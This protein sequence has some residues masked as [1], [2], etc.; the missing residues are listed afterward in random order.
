[1]LLN[2]RSIVNKVHELQ[3]L[4]DALGP[5]FM[6]ITETWLRMSI[7]NSF[8]V[9]TNRY[10]VI[11]RDR[12]D[13]VGGG[14][15]ALVDKQYTVLQVDIVE[16]VEVV[17]FDVIFT[18]CHKYRFILC[19]R[20]PEYGAAACLY[21]TDL[22]K[23]LT[24]LCSV[25]HTVLI[26]GD[27]NLPHVDWDSMNTDGLH[28]DTHRMFV[29]FVRKSGFVQFVSEPTRNNSI[30]DILLANDPQ[31]IADYKLSAPL[32]NSDH[33]SVLFNLV[34]PGVN[35]CVSPESY[36]SEANDLEYKYDFTCTD[37]LGFSA[38]LNSIH[39]E[40]LYNSCADV[41]ECWNC[42]LDVMNDGIHLF[43]PL[44]LVRISNKNAKSYPLHIRKLIRKKCAAWRLYKR[45][46]SVS[47]KQK[48][49]SIRKQ[50]SISIA[51]FVKQ[52]EDSIIRKGNL[53]LFYKYVNNKLSCK[54]GVG[55][56]RDTDGSVI[57]D[58]LSKANVLNDHFSSVFTVDNG[59]CTDFASRTA[60]TLT[61]IT[62][63]AEL[64][65]KRLCKLKVSSSPGPD[66]LHACLLKNLAL[67]LAM[68][69][70][71]LFS[72]SF[73]TSS[74]PDIWKFAV[75]CPVFKKGMSSNVS[76]YRPISLT[77][78][79][80]KIM[81]AIVKDQVISYMLANDLIT[82]QQH[83][84]LSRHSTCS[85]LIESV[86][87]WTL[88]LNAR[89]CVDV[90]YVDFSKAFDCVVHSKLIYKLQS[91]G[92]GGPLLAWIS[93]FLSNRTQAVRVGRDLSSCRQV[94]SGVPQGSVLG[95]LL[96]LLYINDIVDIFGSK[97]GVKL[98]A[99]D[100]KIY[101]VM[102]DVCSKEVLQIGLDNLSVWC[103]NWQMS[104]SVKKCFV[105]QLGHQP[106]NCSYSVENYV[107]PVS[108]VANDL[109]VLI[110]SKLRFSHQYSKITT[111][112]HQRASLI[113]RCFECRDPKLLFRAFTVYVRPILEYCSPVWSPVYKTDVKLLESVQKRFTKKLSGLK[114]MP[115]K[116]RLLFLNTDSL[117][118]RRLRSDLATMYKIVHGFDDT[119]GIFEFRVNSCTRGGEL[120]ILKPH[121]NN[122]VRA[123]SFACRHVD[124]WNELP[125][126][127]RNAKSLC[128]FKRLVAKFDFSNFLVNF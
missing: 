55:V 40:E 6:L 28:D 35:S 73:D 119:T 93:D 17:A 92:I 89:H 30:L 45:Y 51:A 47:L 99:D 3:A 19:Y 76:N 42:F 90:V 122:N 66:G 62:F 4:L 41:N 112:A 81:E 1:V 39:W 75:V 104:L 69:L 48:Y 124:C 15:C 32:A 24:K 37:Y 54:S 27:F 125:E 7:P 83:G 34:L 105:L 11:R 23:C 77:S 84:F 70:S 33:E 100:V 123:H 31:V 43:T 80:C 36:V 88:A 114:H 20:K 67:P 9:D 118:L 109:G 108:E 120:K 116:D 79:V 127:T 101:L 53:G 26:A 110:D 57:S 126:T 87:D 113:L 103:A 49:L 46:K 72:V 85:Q 59:K 98:Y 61:D 44:K 71:L 10:Q 58:D 78:I 14:V 86:N 16:D 22:L 18:G 82:K 106:T 95:P 111:K 117:E 29:D 52:K 121:R 64:V 21:M 102:D 107:L 65:Y 8:F 2:A 5:S 50:C 96:F 56:L 94:I 115:Y 13:T 25:K 12:C 91:Y 74:L 128:S 38:Y 63:T 60:S 97:L 68:P